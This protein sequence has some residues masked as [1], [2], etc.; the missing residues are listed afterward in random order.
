MLFVGAI[1]TADSPNYDSLHWFADEVL[2]LVEKELAWETR[3]T[4]VGFVAPGIN[5]DRLRNH[6]RITLCGAATD[7]EAFYNSH[8]VFVA[9]TRFAAGIPYKLHEAAAFGL[10]I[11]TTELLCLQLGWHNGTELFAAASTDPAG[12]ARHC[13]TL[14]R[15]KQIWTGLQQAGLKRIASDCN[16]MDYEAQILSILNAA[17]VE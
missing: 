12:F 2:P 15:S 8:R 14:Y 4:V 13:V 6:P 7:L 3:L 16:R 17:G 11:V 9:P 1:H 10:P 5:L